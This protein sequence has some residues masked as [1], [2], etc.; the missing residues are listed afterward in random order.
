MTDNLAPDGHDFRAFSL[1]LSSLLTLCSAD[2]MS[3]S[4]I[5][6]DIAT[7]TQSPLRLELCR[8]Y[9]A[10]GGSEKRVDTYNRDLGEYVD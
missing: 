8:A 9:V 3:C 1:D 2:V 5:S 6:R 10:A 4:S 7:G